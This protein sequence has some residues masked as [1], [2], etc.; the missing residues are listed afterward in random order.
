[1]E[2]VGEYKDHTAEKAKEGEET[3]LGKIVELKVTA[4]DAAKRTMG[5]L[6]G[7]REET[8]EKTAETSEAAK[9][10]RHHCLQPCGARLEPDEAAV[11]VYSGATAPP[12]HFSE[13]DT[14][15]ALIGDFQEQYG[16]VIL[17]ET[18]KTPLYPTLRGE[19]RAR[20]GGHVHLFRRYGATETLLGT[21]SKAAL[22]GDFQEQYG[23]VILSETFKT[24]SSPTLHPTLQG[25]TRAGRGGRVRLFQRYGATETLLGTRLGGGID[26]RPSRTV[27]LRDF[28]G[29][30]QDANVSNL[31]S[32]PAG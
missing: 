26:R 10:S 24:P 16:C 2:T 32:N 28:I 27:W 12:R 1:M 13:P 22:I 11:F 17:S 30:F 31:A 6:I 4:V 7:T 23:C 21:D 14:A 3:T 29:D 8:K 19:T 5:F 15:A 18:F 9:L 25:E 20:R